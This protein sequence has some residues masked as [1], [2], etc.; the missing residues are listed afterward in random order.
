MLNNMKTLLGLLL[1]LAGFVFYLVNKN[2]SDDSEAGGFWLPELQND[3]IS[4]LTEI[5]ISKGNEVMSLQKKD[6]EWFVAGGFYADTAPMMS[7][8]QAL[9]SAETVEAKTSNPENFKQLSLAD[10]DLKVTL[11]TGGEVL[12]S[13]HL[14]KKSSAPGA[15]FAR[16]AGEDQTWLVTAIDEVAFMSEDWALKTVMDHGAE[17][18]A[19]V[20]IDNGT[21]A[22]VEISRNATDGNWQLLNI[23]EGKQAKM[24]VPWIQLASGLSRFTIDQALPLELSEKVLKVTANYQLTD[25]SFVEVKLYQHAADYYTT[26]NTEKYAGWMFKVPSYKFDALNKSMLDFIEDATESVVSEDD[27]A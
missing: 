7:M 11:K 21:D 18:V 13:V 6:K 20:Q 8:L 5:E 2:A 12:V 24:D 9:R 27:N 25:A 16:R 17:D 1:L 19:R 26:I 10:D 4:G 15:S 22:V 14:G 3:F 23:P